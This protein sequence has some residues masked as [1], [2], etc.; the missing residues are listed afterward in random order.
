MLTCETVTSV[1]S[2]LAVA[3][4]TDADEARSPKPASSK[5]AVW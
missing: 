2:S 3:T 4:M 5:M 1:A